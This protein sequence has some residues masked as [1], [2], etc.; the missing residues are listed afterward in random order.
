[1]GQGAGRTQGDARHGL[2][3]TLSRLVNGACRGGG[4]GTRQRVVVGDEDARELEQGAFTGTRES[5]SRTLGPQKAG[6][7]Y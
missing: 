5:G 6:F 1:M 3:E 4:R 7:S 2:L